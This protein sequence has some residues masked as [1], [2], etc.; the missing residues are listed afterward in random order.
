MED[1]MNG[2]WIP[3][4]ERLPELWGKG[5]SKRVLVTAKAFGTRYIA[6]DWLERGEW[7]NCDVVAWMPLPEV[8]G[9]TYT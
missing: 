8:Y 7:K 6:I 5:T 2:E 3:V 9:R 1:D 4:A